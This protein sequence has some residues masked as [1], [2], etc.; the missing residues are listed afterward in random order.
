MPPEAHLPS[1]RL[2]QHFSSVAVQKGRNRRGEATASNVPPLLDDH[3][4]GMWGEA[5]GRRRGLV[6]I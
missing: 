4:R 6:G 1:H 5:E 2:A 3:I